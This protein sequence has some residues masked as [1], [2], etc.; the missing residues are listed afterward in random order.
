MA[1]AIRLQAIIWN[2]VRAFDKRNKK[3][4]WCGEK[5]LIN[6]LCIDDEVLNDVCF[7]Y[8]VVYN[9]FMMILTMMIS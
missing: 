5:P 6:S 8:I 7:C 2:G 4:M 1:A 9:I 3:K